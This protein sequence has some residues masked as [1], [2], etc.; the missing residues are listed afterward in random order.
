MTHTIAVLKGDGIGPEVTEAALSVLGACVP[1][2]V[3]EALVG[4]AAIDATGDPLPSA[5]LETCLRSEAVLLGAVGGPRWEGTIRAEDG[6]LRLR[7]S[8]GL[9]ANLRPARFMGL[10][11]PLREALARHADILVVRELSGGV[12]FGQPRGGDGNEAFNTWRQSAAQVRRVA[13]VAFRAARRRRRR[14]TSV[15]KANVL[16][17]SRLWRRVVTEVAGEYPDV[18]LEHRYVDAAAFE[19]LKAPHRFDVVLTENL[20]GDIL[21]DEVGV[22]AGSIGLLPSASLGEGPSLYEPVHGSAPDLAGRGTANPAGAI[23]SVAMMLELSFGRAELAR[24]LEAAVMAT[25]RETRTPDLGGRA[26]TAEFTE[27]VRH[28]LEWLRWSHPSPE[29]EASYEWGV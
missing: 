6:L 7:Q 10:P 20:F 14:V 24:S 25:L 21:S 8:L 22:V 23:L 11:T 9:F 5:T 16:E 26:T 19:L 28:N 3:R 29:D 2:R 15:D 13:H 4:G 27:A 17:A 18:E 12:Y 1:V